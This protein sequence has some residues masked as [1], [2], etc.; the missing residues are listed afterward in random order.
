[1]PCKSLTSKTLNCDVLNKAVPIKSKLS[2]CSL[3]S[4]R[5]VS[6]R[7]QFAILDS[8]SEILEP[9]DPPAPV[10]N[11][12]SPSKSM[13]FRISEICKFT[14]LPNQ[15]AQKLLLRFSNEFYLSAA[16]ISLS[17]IALAR[18]SPCGEKTETILILIRSASE[19]AR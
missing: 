6:R 12:L 17:L 3:F 15:T 14:F 9:I 19:S 7:I 1:M 2:V 13:L 11:T 10:I 8:S 4:S 5:S 18:P 16:L